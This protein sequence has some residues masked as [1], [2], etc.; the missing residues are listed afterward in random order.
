MKKISLIGS[1]GSIGRQVIE[2]VKRY[3][4]EYKIV[5]LAA[6]SDKAEFEKQVAMFRPELYALACEDKERALSV[7]D[8]PEADIVFN[9][10]GGFAGL[11]YSFRAVNAGKTLALANK[12]TLVCGG[13][14]IIPLAEKKGVELSPLTASILQFGSA[15]IMKKLLP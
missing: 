7:A 15:L 3:P 6:G 2:V 5:A 13:D 10:A 9:A 4:E 12:E 8:Y 11:E 1:T 14:V